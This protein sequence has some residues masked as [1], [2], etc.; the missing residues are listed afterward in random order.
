M[1]AITKTGKKIHG[2]IAEILV[3]KG[4]ATPVEELTEEQLLAQKQEEELIAAELK[5]KKRIEKEKKDA[6]KKAKALKK[7]KK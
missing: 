7:A 1:E 5:E 2:R 4:I 6:A 3:N